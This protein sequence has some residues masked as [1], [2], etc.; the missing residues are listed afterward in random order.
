MIGRLAQFFLYTLT[1]T[2]HN[3]L[4]EVDLSGTILCSELKLDEKQNQFSKMYDVAQ[5]SKQGTATLTK[6]GAYFFEE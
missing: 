2:N 4:Q 6:K 3:F 5:A 1:A